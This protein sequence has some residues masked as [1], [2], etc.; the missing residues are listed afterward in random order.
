M[1]R[2]LQPSSKQVAKMRAK[3]LVRSSYVGLV[4]NAIYDSALAAF[5]ASLGGV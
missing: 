1:I 4:G 3:S 2:M 5:G